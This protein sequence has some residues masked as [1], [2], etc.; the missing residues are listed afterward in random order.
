MVDSFLVYEILLFLLDLISD[1]TP[2][3]VS[4]MLV[5]AFLCESLIVVAKCWCF[6]MI[7]AFTRHPRKQSP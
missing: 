3:T 6:R 4:T 1:K 5:V 7:W 2:G